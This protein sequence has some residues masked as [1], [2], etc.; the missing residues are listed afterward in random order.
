MVGFPPLSSQ[1]YI[2][3][4][5]AVL[6]KFLK[7][8]FTSLNLSQCFGRVLEVFCHAFVMLLPFF[9]VHSG[10]EVTAGIEK[11]WRFLPGFCRDFAEFLPGF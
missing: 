6:E 1:I 7:Y 10:A 4:Q 8:Y 2:S 11:F 3:L 5:F 9:V